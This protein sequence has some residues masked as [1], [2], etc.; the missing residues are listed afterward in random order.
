MRPDVPIH[1]KPLILQRIDMM[2]TETVSQKSAEETEIETIDHCPHRAR[3]IEAGKL[4]RA[5][6]E[7]LEREY[8]RRRG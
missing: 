2:R 3:I 5:E 7:R 1:A 8:R 4:A 6:Q